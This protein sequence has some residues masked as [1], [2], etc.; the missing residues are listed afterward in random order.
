MKAFQAV[1]FFIPAFNCGKTIEESVESIMQGN[2]SGD[3]ELIIVDDGSTDDTGEAIRR[4]QSKYPRTV[5]VRH[6]QNRGGAR[7]RNTAVERARNSLLFC[8][9]SDNLL[10]PGSVPALKDFLIS[11]GADVAAFGKYYYFNN[12]PGD[13]SEIVLFP[14][15]TTLESIFSD[16]SL[17]GTSGNY[18]F[19]KKSWEMAG[20][21]PEFAGALDTWGFGFRQVVTGSKMVAMKDSFYYHRKGHESYFVREARTGKIPLIAIQIVAPYFHIF[22]ERSLRYMTGRKGRQNWIFRLKKHPVRLKKEFRT[23]R[24]TIT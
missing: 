5:V 15:I 23:K 14:S 16:T 21:Y 13:L 20:G 18:L 19:T 2:F 4:I 12:R 24:R 10:V 6:E 11:S 22:E 7:A 8:L 3:D 17:P 9:D 1:S